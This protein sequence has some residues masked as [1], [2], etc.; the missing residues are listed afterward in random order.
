[1]TI[2]VVDDDPD[3]RRLF[4][5]VLESVGVDIT[6]ETSG[7]NA[8][9]Q[10]KAR[11]FDLIFMDLLMPGLNGVYAIEK[12]QQVRPGMRIIAMT[13]HASPEVVDKALKAGA[14][15]C[16]YKPLT[17]EHIIEVTERIREELGGAT[18][19]QPS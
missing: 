11:K 1:M 7:F 10:V 19:P 8:L 4:Q 16:L 12:I 3:T 15:F 14:E 18:Q 17:P 2:L 9:V 13:G 5:T 6:C